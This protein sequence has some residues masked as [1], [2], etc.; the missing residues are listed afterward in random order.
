MNKFIENLK[1]SSTQIRTTHAIMAGEDAKDAQEDLIRKLRK[2]KRDL[3]R[4]YENLT[5]ISRDSEISLKVAKD[6]FDPMEWVK[7][8]QQIK[9]DIKMITF[10]LKIADETL[11]EWF[12]EKDNKD[13]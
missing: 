11:A 2:Q 5:D 1:K 3:E 10:E 9:I 13:E 6:Q 8:L 12:V 4:K 7:D